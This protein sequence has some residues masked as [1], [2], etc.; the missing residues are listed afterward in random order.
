M[1]ICNQWFASR[2]ATR[3]SSAEHLS[4]VD[5][6]VIFFDSSAALTKSFTN[7]LKRLLF[8]GSLKISMQSNVIVPANG[9]SLSSN[10]STLS[11]KADGS[12]AKQWVGV[13]I[14]K[15]ATPRKIV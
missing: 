5:A 14:T 2:Q 8:F 1:T 9:E 10:R 11:F 12:Q 13:K 15:T 3:T 7:L 4:I 6:A